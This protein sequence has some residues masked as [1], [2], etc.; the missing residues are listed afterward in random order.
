MRA[1]LVRR[2]RP[3]RTPKTRI[4]IVYRLAECLGFGP[5]QPPQREEG[6]R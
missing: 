6:G 1:R 2:S 5:I 4:L 3:H